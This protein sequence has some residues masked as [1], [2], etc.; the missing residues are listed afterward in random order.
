ME[1][2]KVTYDFRNKDGFL[3]TVVEEFAGLEQAMAAVR[4][5]SAKKNTVG[6]PLLETA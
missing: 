1:K 5:I 4:V 3:E 6:T 2:Q